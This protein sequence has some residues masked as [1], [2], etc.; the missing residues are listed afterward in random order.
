MSIEIARVTPAHVPELAEICYHA[1]GSL[2]DRHGVERDFDRPETAAMVIGLFAGRP[3]FAGFVAI[4]RRPEADGRL[5]G[6]NFIS[7]SD[8]VAGVGPITVRPDAQARGVGKLLMQAVMDEAR[9]RGVGQVRLLQE[10]INTSSLSLYTKLGFDWQEAVALM[11]PTP[12]AADHPAARRITERDLGEIDR[13]SR[14]HY[15]STRVNEVAGYLKID[16][17]GFILDRAGRAV[18]YYFPSFFGHGFAETAEDLAD[19]IAHTLR[20]CPPEFHKALLPLGQN[21]LHRAL[22]ARGG[23]TIKLVNYMTTG[24]FK[25][26][27]G[28]WISSIGM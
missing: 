8:P 7:F 10:A 21:D 19:L 9:R 24:E 5:L 18:G 1:F 23:R 11:R 12:A 16:L 2:H 15:H 25:H 22:L 26:P 4:D 6:S 13:L 20:H 28:A 3:D 14:R 27:D 17:P